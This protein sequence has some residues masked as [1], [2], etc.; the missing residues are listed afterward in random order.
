MD[1]ESARTRASR[2][3]PWLK[4]GC[5]GCL[6]IGGL[7]LG[8]VLVVALVASV[9][10]RP[11]RMEDHELRP[12]IPLEAPR[13]GSVVLDIREAELRVEPAGPGEPLRIEARYDVN[14]FALEQRLEPP[15]GVD[16]A[17]TYRATFRRSGGAGTFAGLVSLIRGSTARIR[18]FLPADV[19]VDL[20]LR[21]KEG[22]TVVRLGGLWL[23]TAEIELESAALDLD[24]ADPL[25]EPMESLSIRAAKGGCLLNHLGNAS[26][27]RLDV[28]YRM[29]GIDMDLG[30][31]WLAD[32]TISIDGGLGGGVVHLPA[33]VILEGL[34]LPVIAAPTTAE[35]KPPTLKFSVSTRVGRLELSDIRPR[36]LS[37][38]P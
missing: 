2:R 26:P 3:G 15:T 21:L 14:A 7:A 31:R 16:G 27:R 4:Y 12:E 23:R 22:G 24:V 8:V 13:G 1:S 38:L 6:G 28:R 32:A 10:A 29:G 37:R 30:G 5:F 25:R 33:G 11:E 17:W 18:V 35:L 9:T 19:P 34:D 20:S 36:D